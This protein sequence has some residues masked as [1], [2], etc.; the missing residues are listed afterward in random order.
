MSALQKVNGILINFCSAIAGLSNELD[1][2]WNHEQVEEIFWNMCENVRWICWTCVYFIWCNQMFRFPVYII[3]CMQ[4][5][6]Q[7]S[8]ACVQGVKPIILKALSCQWNSRKAGKYVAL[9]FVKKQSVCFSVSHFFWSDSL[10][11]H[12]YVQ[13]M[14]NF[15]TLVWRNPT[16]LKSSNCLECHSAFK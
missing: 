3:N 6:P 4:C 8:V 11:L 10:P 13:L 2:D 5:L 7:P 16:F 15:G 12:P 14:C 1:I 9:H